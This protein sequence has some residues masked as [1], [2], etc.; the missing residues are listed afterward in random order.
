MTLKSKIQ[1]K[2]DSFKKCVRPGP[3]AMLYFLYCIIH[4]LYNLKKNRL[5]PVCAIHLST[6]LMHYYSMYL[7]SNRKKISLMLSNK[8]QT[9]LYLT[10]D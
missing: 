8:C 9:P 5:L 3:K 7:G 10:F 4:L 1:N 2:K 6:R